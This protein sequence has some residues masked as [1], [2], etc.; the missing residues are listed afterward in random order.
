[1]V[2]KFFEMVGEFVNLTDQLFLIPNLA[3]L[4]KR[5]KARLA[6]AFFHN[7][8]IT[9]SFPRIK[10]KLLFLKERHLKCWKKEGI[11]GDFKK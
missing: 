6:L 8:A 4:A 10:L 11:Y 5:K 1:M 7:S 2:A 3:R 9:N